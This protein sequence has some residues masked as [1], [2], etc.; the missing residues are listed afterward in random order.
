M[1]KKENVR[2]WDA[3][4]GL[5]EHYLRDL[6]EFSHSPLRVNDDEDEDDVFIRVGKA[7]TELAIELLEVNFSADFPYV[8]ENY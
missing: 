8:D 6:L 7:I 1:D 4:D 5:T 2:Y 3:I